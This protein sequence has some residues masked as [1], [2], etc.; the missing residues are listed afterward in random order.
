M[1]PLLMAA[2]RTDW[3]TVVNGIIVAVLLAIVTAMGTFAANDRNKI[4][5]DLHHS[6]ERIAVLEQRNVSLESES[7]R[8]RDRID[9]LEQQLIG[10]QQVLMDK[11]REP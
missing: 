3:K 4:A 5:D 1:A 2:T 6:I 8:A 9:A 7:K 10:L 11:R